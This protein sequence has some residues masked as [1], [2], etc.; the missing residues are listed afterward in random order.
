VLS[1][2]YDAQSVKVAV[3]LRQRH[4]TRLVLDLCDNHFYADSDDAVWK[5]RA[6]DLRAAVN[7]VDVVVA[8]SSALAEIVS[9]E[10]RTG[11]PVVV[12]G[13]A[14]EALTHPSGLVRLAHPLAAWQLAQLRSNLA[15]PEIGA[16]RKLVWFGNHGSGYAD[17][18]MADLSALR[19][20]LEAANLECPLSL[21]VVSNHRRK[22][23][24]LTSNWRIKTHYL[25]WHQATFS[26]ALCLHDVAVIPIG[27]NPFTVCKTSN[28]AATALAH[29]LAVAADSIPSYQALGDCIV[30]D[31]WTAGL[32]KLLTDPGFRLSSV[33]RG[34]A[35]VRAECSI[36]HIAGR[37]RDVLL[38]REAGAA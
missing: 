28:R 2:R 38:E 6:D 1:K 35:L 7:A 25:E 33:S 29:G 18:G 31:D 26:R 17:G 34:A 20:V 5:H 3:E 27:R 15:T 16:G 4:G 36:E 30:L 37:W 12:I 23:A 13:D 21:T 10:A 14:V 11:L 8:A 24:D 22:F 19:E 9:A 32:H